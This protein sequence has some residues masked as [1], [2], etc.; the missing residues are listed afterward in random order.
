MKRASVYFSG[1]VQGV[2]FRYTCRSIAKGFSLTGYVKNLDDGRVE[3]KVE[4]EKEEI[5]DF[6]G[7]IGKSHLKPF[8]KQ[9]TVDWSDAIGEWQDFHINQ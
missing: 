8:I 2:G 4:G 1:R 5:E 6:L 3:M 9:T 7:D